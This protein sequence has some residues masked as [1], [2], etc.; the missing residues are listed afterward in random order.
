MKRVVRIMAIIVAMAVF[1]AFAGC[2]K[3]DKNPVI[4]IIQY[5]EHVA[6]DSSREGFIQA[7]NDNGYVEGENITTK[8]IFLPSATALSATKW[9]SCWQ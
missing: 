9:I 7:L 2:A 3:K 4:G 1:A 5:A 6:L 8:P